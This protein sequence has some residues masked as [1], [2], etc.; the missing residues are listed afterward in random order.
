MEISK[1]KKS[2]EK[3]WDRYVMKSEDSTFYHQI[4]WKNV[5][6]KTY[7]HKPIYLIAREDG[8]IKGILPLFLMKSRL[9]GKKL[10]SVPFAPY[11]GV[12]ADNDKVLDSILED[13]ISW[14]DELDVDY[15][16]LRSYMRY[17]ID[18]ITDKSYFTLNLDLTPGVDYLWNGFRK[19]MRRYIKKAGRNNLEFTIES[20]SSKNLK[21]FYELYC[22]KMK[23]FGTP[24]HSYKFFKLIKSEF[25]EYIK[26]AT[27]KYQTYTIAALFLLIFKKTMIYGWGASDKQYTS[28]YPN[29]LLFWELIKYMNKN[30]YKYLDFGRSILNDGTFLFKKGWG[31]KPKQLY[32]QYYG[33]YNVTMSS[34]KF[35]PRRQIFMKIWKIIPIEIV[36]MI[37]PMIRKNF[38]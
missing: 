13:A 17:K 25:P 4:G 5:V 34:N 20:K 3:E 12:C 33:K 18:G 21:D 10:V 24:T 31:A 26:I 32:Y 2:D 6:E 15:L 37:G 11:G 1:L 36:N 28:M 7:G 14:V 23:E 30:G 8:E 35:N 22:K 16:E 9:F 29:Y 38:P 27:V 19:S